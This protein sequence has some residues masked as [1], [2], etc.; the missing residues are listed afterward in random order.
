MH[1]E[2]AMEYNNVNI[3]LYES[4]I[5][6]LQMRLSKL[7]KHIRVSKSIMK[8]KQLEIQYTE[9]RKD[10]LMQM[11]ILN[12]LQFGNMLWLLRPDHTSYF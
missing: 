6:Y 7:K 10:L 1:F 5:K 3:R 4:K 11:Q 12:L 9:L 8:Q 2:S